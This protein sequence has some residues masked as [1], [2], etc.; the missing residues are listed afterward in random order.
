MANGIEKERALIAAL[1]E[2]FSL[3][4]H[5][6]WDRD[7]GI[8]VMIR[9]LKA[10]PIAR[11]PLAVQ[12]TWNRG[13]WNKQAM[14]YEKARGIAERVIF[15]EINS[16]DVNELLVAGVRTVLAQLILDAG[17]PT[18]V[19]IEINQDGR[20]R[21]SDMEARLADFRRKLEEIIE[22]DIIGYL[23]YWN[24]DIGFADVT[25]GDET[26]TFFCNRRNADPNTVE[27][28]A[29][30]SGQIETRDQPRVVFSDGGVNRNSEYRKFALGLRLA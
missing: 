13:N 4:T 21:I 16:R 8:D 5:K 9:G 17:A 29:G 28:L 6:S 25:F 3:D 7:Y 15:L 12:I 22:G 26:I 2:Y 23:T 30:Y 20:Y 19:I 18:H 14:T 11:T 24:G 1:A 27:K 10:P